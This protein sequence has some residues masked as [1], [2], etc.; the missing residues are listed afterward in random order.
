MRSILEGICGCEQDNALF[1][2]PF[3]NREAAFV[4]GAAGNNNVLTGR[5]LL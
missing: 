2:W 3:K 1:L 5:R 4:C